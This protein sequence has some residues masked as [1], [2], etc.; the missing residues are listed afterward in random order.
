MWWVLFFQ[1]LAHLNYK[2]CN[3]EI[4]PCRTLAIPGNTCV[5]NTGCGVYLYSCS[6]LIIYRFFS[7]R[8]KKRVISP[9]SKGRKS[10][11][12]R[13]VY[14]R[15][16]QR[17][18]LFI[19]LYTWPEL[20]VLQ[21]LQGTGDLRIKQRKDLKQYQRCTGPIQRSRILRKNGT[22]PMINQNIFWNFSCR[23]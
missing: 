20:P 21:L 18:S 1:F 19:I 17:R 8:E 5:W 3:P 23:R 16:W 22:K 11:R 6:W 2:D 13:D 14:N 7:F 15:P 4:K 12:S 9:C 10:G